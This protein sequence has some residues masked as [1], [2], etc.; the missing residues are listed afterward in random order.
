MCRKCYIIMRGSIIGKISDYFKE[1][2]T[3]MSIFKKMLAMTLV[4]AMLLLVGCSQDND[5]S[6]AAA[7]EQDDSQIIAKVDDSVVN[8]SYFEK[9]YK[10]YGS[11]Y[12]H[13][14]G[15][16][17][18][19]RDYN[20]QK[21]GDVLKSDVVEMLI[22]DQLVRNYMTSTGYTVD[23]DKVNENLTEL[24]DNMAPELV[25]LYS[26]INIDDAFL[27][28]QVQ[29]SLISDAFQNTIFDQ[30]DQ[31]QD[32]LNEMYDTYPVK[33]S[34]RHILVAD[35][36]TAELV[37]SKLDAG[38]DFAELAKE[39]SQD[40]ATADNGGD[41]GYFT[42]GQ[43][44]KEFEDTAFSLNVGEISAPV[45]SSY[46]Y[47]IIKCDDRQTVNDLIAAG[48][49]EDSINKFKTQIKNNLFD[50]YFSKKMDEITAGATVERFADNIP[51]DIEVPT[52]VVE[53]E[54]TTD[55][56]TTDDQKIDDQST[57][58]QSTDDQKTDDQSTD[59]QSTDDQKTD[60]QSTEGSSN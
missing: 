35:Q 22:Q 38:E 13:Q 24:K 51:A 12:K 40:P 15:D 46:G 59:D 20:G 53:T 23:A 57:D 50:E 4:F 34:A 55:D 42:R 60:D 47:H 44:V 19:D 28:D 2:K 54:P 58:D 39:Y 29:G 43:M 7:S 27:T 16:D 8:S 49:S 56:Q 25:K 26:D 18:L 6:G 9:Y 1:R 21:F 14:Y 30:I 5:Q 37:K 11:L 31:D 52:I 48:E 36:A 3:I 17:I 33:V 32:R 41:L 10:L 45:Q